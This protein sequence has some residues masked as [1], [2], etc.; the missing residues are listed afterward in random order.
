MKYCEKCGDKMADDSLF[1]AINEEG[2]GRLK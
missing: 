2:V 1:S